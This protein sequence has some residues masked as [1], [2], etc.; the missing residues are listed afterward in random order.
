MESWVPVPDTGRSSLPPV[1]LPLMRILLFL[2]PAVA[3][4]YVTLTV[5]FEPG[6]LVE[7]QVVPVTTKSLLSEEKPESCSGTV[8]VTVSVTGCGVL[9]VLISWGANVRAVGESVAV[10]QVP[11]PWTAILVAPPV[12]LSLR[13]IALLFSAVVPGVN[14]MLRVQLAPGTLVAG[15]MAQVVLDTAKAL[16]STVML[17]IDSGTAPVTVSVTG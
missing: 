4:V 2:R 5:Q 6:A 17:E 3:G 8:P 16:S 10:D 12:A 7:K 15:A 14:V 13:W 11:V 1:K 9:G